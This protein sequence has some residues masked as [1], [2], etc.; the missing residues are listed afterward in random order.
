MTG[1][2]CG[3]ENLNCSTAEGYVLRPSFCVGR[4][5]DRC[6][7]S[8]WRIRTQKWEKN[9][10]ANGLGI[11]QQHG[12]AVNSNSLPGSGR[13]TVAERANVIGVNLFGNLITTL[14]DLLQEAALPLARSLVQACG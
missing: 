13:H 3:S 4:I 1:Q 11:G 9:N 14:G 6:R 7:T 5:F 2:P 8:I 12:Q 10:V